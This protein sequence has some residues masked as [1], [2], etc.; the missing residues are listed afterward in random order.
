MS[1]SSTSNHGDTGW[2][3]FEIE[4]SGTCLT[5]DEAIGPENKSAIFKRKIKGISAGRNMNFD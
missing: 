5:L 4:V 2:S 3:F 1:K